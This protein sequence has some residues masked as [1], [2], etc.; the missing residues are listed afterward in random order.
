MD[1]SV[2]LCTYNRSDLLARV[3]QDLDNSICPEDMEW[4]VLV[5][6]NNSSDATKSVVDSFIRKNPQRFRYIFEGRQGKSIALNT[7]VESAHGNILAFTDDDVLVDSKWVWQ[8]KRAFDEFDCIGVGGRI[9][10]LF[11]TKPPSWLIVDSWQPFLNALVAFEFGEKFSA[12][13]I[14]PF[15]ANMAFR[16]T[17]FAKYGGFR[18]DL[19]PTGKNQGGKGEDTEFGLRLLAHN[20]ALM[21]APDAIVYHP[22]EKGRMTKKYFRTWYFN[23]GRYEAK[24][25]ANIPEQTTFYFGV[26]R[27]YLRILIDRVLLWMG[28]RD[29]LMRSSCE[30]DIYKKCGIIRELL[31][32]KA[33]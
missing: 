3:L 31:S 28:T 23:Q 18:V 15:G 17:A 6:D 19:G 26:P 8:L 7:G 14:P 24:T 10:P 25:V 5:V 33:P 32:S 9:V 29:K 11:T 4:E 27:F 16:K 13:R 30:M 21:Y 22:V 12:L 20:E 2:I 1:I